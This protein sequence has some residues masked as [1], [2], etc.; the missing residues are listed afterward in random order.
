MF[1][2]PQDV[3]DSLWA[4]L[5]MNEPLIT[6]GSRGYCFSVKYALV[7]QGDYKFAVYEHPKLGVWVFK[8]E[9]EALDEFNRYLADRQLDPLTMEELQRLKEGRHNA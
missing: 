5:V 3:K 2:F 1:I 6:E 4:E 9:Q 8:K 7:K